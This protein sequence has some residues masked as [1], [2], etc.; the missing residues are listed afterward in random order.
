MSR[1]GVTELVFAGDLRRFRLGIDELLALQDKLDA[2]P[3]EIAGRLRAGTWRV[4]DVQ[5]TFRIGLIGGGTDARKAKELVDKHIA[6]GKLAARVLEAWAIVANAIYGDED[7][8]AGKPQA[9]TDAT[10]D[11]SPQVPSMATPPS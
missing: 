7:D 8:P 11:G 3:A 2:G 10:A 1:D 6:P 9:G 4:Q 5:E